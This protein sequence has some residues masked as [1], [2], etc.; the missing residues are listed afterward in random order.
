MDIFTISGFPHYESVLS[1]W[2]NYFLNSDNN[3]SLTGLFSDSLKSLLILKGSSCSL[4]WLNDQVSCLPEV[5]TKKKNFV[6]LVVYDSKTSQLNQFENALVIEHKVY[7]E[8]YN[9]LADYFESIEVIDEKQG[10]I[11]SAKQLE[12]PNKNFI[13][14]TYKELIVEITKNL[15]SYS[16]KVDMINF[17]YL[18]DFMNNIER[19]S[20]TKNR[21]ALEFCF[22]HG[23]TIDE[24]VNLKYRAEEDLVNSV[25]LSL[26]PTNYY[27]QRRNPTN[28]VLRSKSNVVVIY[29]GL[30]NLFSKRECGVQ[31][32]L[33]GSAVKKWN[34]VPN[35]S[36]LKMNFS[37]SFEIKEKKEG[38]EW[39]ELLTGT[40][41]LS[42]VEN[43]YETFDQELI[44][45]LTEKI[46]PVTE[47]IMTRIEI[48]NQ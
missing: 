17:S 21:E 26:E 40:M 48:H 9:D 41:D 28:F 36:E 44:K 12:I 43:I 5:Q 42:G 20:D 35:H 2:F 6:D 14:I 45:F 46:D 32:W 10:V 39:V 15:G 18:R 1:N 23:K 7:A 30:T 3:H 34:Q 4:D 19:M 11:L 31:Y 22:K 24:I 33:Q 8:L 38:N 29:V 47:F 37:G 13:N 27:L 25:R 16:L